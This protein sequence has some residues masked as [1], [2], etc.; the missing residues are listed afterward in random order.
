MII[1][2]QWSLS[3]C[4]ERIFRY[5]SY[6]VRYAQMVLYHSAIAL[7]SSQHKHSPYRIIILDF[8]IFFYSSSSPPKLNSNRLD[9]LQWLAISSEYLL[10]VLRIW[11]LVFVWCMRKIMPNDMDN[12]EF[13]SVSVVFKYHSN[14][15]SNHGN[16]FGRKKNA[17]WIRKVLCLVFEDV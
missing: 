2:C 13:N 12:L 14:H 5:T 4:V 3:V 1:F 11:H 8:A 9:C 10:L 7:A 16:I 6:G 17:I 15:I